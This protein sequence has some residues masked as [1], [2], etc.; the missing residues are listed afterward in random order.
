MA[1]RLVFAVDRGN[2]FEDVGSLLVGSQ[3]S[4]VGGGSA[5]SFNRASALLACDIARLQ[6]AGALGSTLVGPTTVDIVGGAAP[7]GHLMGRRG[8]S[9]DDVLAGLAKAVGGV[10]EMDS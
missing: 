1:D 8:R 10:A 3:W 4:F 7:A 6:D 2:V 5:A 9:I